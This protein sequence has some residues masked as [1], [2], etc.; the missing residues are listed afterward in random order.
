V[1]HTVE[2]PNKGHFGTTLFVLCKEAVLFGR[3]KMYYNYREDVFWDLKS[4][5][6]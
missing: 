5:P 3:L 4:C 6:L 2:P 1:S